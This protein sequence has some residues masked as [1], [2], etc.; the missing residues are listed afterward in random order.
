MYRLSV[1]PA[2]PGTSVRQFWSSVPVRS[3]ELTQEGD[4]SSG[5]ESF[6]SRRPLGLDAGDDAADLGGTTDHTF[7]YGPQGSVRKSRT[8]GRRGMASNDH[9]AGEIGVA[10]LR[11]GGLRAT[12]QVAG[13]QLKLGRPYRCDN[14]LSASADQLVKVMT[15]LA[16]CSRHF[17][18]GVKVVE[19][20]CIDGEEILAKGR[21]GVVANRPNQ[22]S[23]Q[24]IRRQ[25]QDRRSRIRTSQLIRDCMKQVC[26]PGTSAAVEQQ[27]IVDLARVPADFHA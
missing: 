11:Q 27:W 13:E 14:N 21:Y 20:K 12:G 25:S 18:Q 22:T 10:D 2:A 4:D 24:G 8:D 7:R 17:G 16:Q 6:P 19:E 26:L 15:D 3:S 1:S 9:A 23:C 5:A